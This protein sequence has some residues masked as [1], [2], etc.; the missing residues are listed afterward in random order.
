MK[1]VGRDLW[2]RVGLLS[3]T[4]LGTVA[5]LPVPASAAP[6]TTALKLT[7]PK[8]AVPP[9]GKAR[10][11]ATLTAAGKPLAGKGI[12][13]LAGTAAAGQATT[14]SKGRAK[15]TV[16]LT[17]PTA[18]TATYTPAGADAAAYKPA[19]SAPLQLAPSARVTVSI[20]SYLRAG[21][22]AVGIPGSRVR[23]RGTLAP[24]T[25]GAKV[26][27]SVFRNGRRVQ[28]KSAVVK[29]AGAVG[30]YAVSIKPSKRGVHRVRVRQGTSSDSARL[31]VV[32]PRANPGS[33]GTAVRALQRRLK[34]LGYLTPVSG[35][36]DG[37]TAR[38]VL[39]FRKVNG[40]ARI[41]SAGRTVYRR[42]ARGGG[43]FKIRYPKAG[44]HAEF[45]WSRQVLVLARGAKPAI[46]L[47]ASS[48]ASATPTVLGKYHFYR[49]SPGYN[50]KGM[51]YSS[52]FTGGYAIH[53]YSPVPTFPASHGCLRIP[54]ASAKRVYGWVSLGDPI[55]TYR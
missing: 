35:K 48:G 27:V 37:T 12:A 20:G 4:A 2:G 40:F 41:T 54:I 45:D 33:R 52:Y 14:D 6:V 13:F 49:K 46:I 51:Y 34:D 17:A 44:K 38:A 25:A 47:H 9:G 7:G 30:R 16:T 43:G 11:T 39:A 26:E 21:R 22:R 50:A 31:Y 29:Q 53:G 3:I 23:V 18:Y 42:L 32:R 5:L 19:Q 24:Y 1:L 55:Y 28:R 10:L 36:F 8:G 15:L